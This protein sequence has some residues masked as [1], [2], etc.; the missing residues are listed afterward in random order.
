MVEFFF[1]FLKWNVLWNKILSRYNVLTILVC[2]TIIV[3]PTVN[4][5]DFPRPVS[6]NVLLGSCPFQCVGT[7]WINGSFFTVENTGDKVVNEN[8][9]G[10]TG[11]N[12]KYGHQ[13]LYIGQLIEH[14]ERRIFIVTSWHP[15][16]TH[17]VHWEKYPIRTNCGNPEVDIT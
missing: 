6:V 7:P 3:S 4:M 1:V 12:R 14:W 5:W 16:H 9:L 17:K 10:Q 8:Q 11:N 13:N 15:G 2:F